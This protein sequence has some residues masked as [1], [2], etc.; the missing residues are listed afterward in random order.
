MNLQEGNIYIG[1]VMDYCGG[2]RRLNGN[3]GYSEKKAST[4]GTKAI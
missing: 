1:L 3:Y 4:E 2:S